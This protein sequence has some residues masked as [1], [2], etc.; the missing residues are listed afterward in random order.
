MA[1]K[2]L[3]PNKR[4][5]VSSLD[6]IDS[7]SQEAVEKDDPFWEMLANIAKG[8]VFKRAEL[9]AELQNLVGCGLFQQV[10]MEA[11]AQQDGTV[12][13]RSLKPY[14]APYG[15]AVAGCAQRFVY[16]CAGGGEV[17]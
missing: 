5:K 9:D 17:R 4:Y 2:N 16:L 13:V 6:L 11:V 14:G 7:S 10:G 3:N 1:I 8:G 15:A 12:K